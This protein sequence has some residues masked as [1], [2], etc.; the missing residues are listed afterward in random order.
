MTDQKKE[1]EPKKYTTYQLYKMFV[2]EK[3]LGAEFKEF[4][5]KHGA[6]KSFICP[7][8]LALCPSKW[9]YENKHLKQK[10]HTRYI[11]NRRKFREEA[12]KDYAKY[13]AD[14][15]KA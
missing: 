9:Y 8:C 3:K 5:Y 2:E 15:K 1:P 10:T 12:E 14:Q 13:K 7:E 4:T 11:E 6:N